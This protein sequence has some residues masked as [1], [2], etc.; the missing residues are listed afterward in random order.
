MAGTVQRMEKRNA[1]KLSWEILKKR[2]D[3]EY[4]GLDR[5]IL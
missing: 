5:R 3:V 1:Y 4:L 2:D